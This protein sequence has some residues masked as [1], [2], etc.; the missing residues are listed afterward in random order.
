[1]WLTRRFLVRLPSSWC[2]VFGRHCSQVV[3]KFPDPTAPLTPTGRVGRVHREALR[4]P[5]HQIV[6][7]AALVLAALD[8]RGH[9]RMLVA[10]EEFVETGDAE[11]RWIDEVRSS[12]DRSVAHNFV[13]VKAGASWAVETD[14]FRH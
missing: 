4:A 1:M 9:V 5:L 2:L 7:E 13:N 11:P 12:P 6:L 3:P 10:I 8:R 14:G